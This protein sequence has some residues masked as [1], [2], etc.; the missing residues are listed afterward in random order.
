MMADNNKAIKD[1]FKVMEKTTKDS[2]KQINRDLNNAFD[3]SKTIVK[4]NK[5]IDRAMEQAKEVLEVLV[6][7]LDVNLMPH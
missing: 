1:G 2:A 5:D 4:F 3:I 6:M 7:I